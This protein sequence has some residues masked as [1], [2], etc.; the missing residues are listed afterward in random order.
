[1]KLLLLELLERLLRRE[2]LAGPAGR[3][4]LNLTARHS[5]QPTERQGK[6]NRRAI[7]PRTRSR[8]I[9]DRQ[10]ASL[11]AAVLIAAVA[12]AIKLQPPVRA[13]QQDADASY[14]L[15][16]RVLAIARRIGV[17]DVAEDER[18]SAVWA[19][20]LQARKKAQV[21]WEIDTKRWKDAL[22]AALR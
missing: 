4:R 9:T 2:R 10:L 6:R 22:Y 7:T 19:Q 15:R 13:G 18:N 12:I 21:C 5:G 3:G 14:E 17:N 20:P 16:A 8:T 11:L 1:M